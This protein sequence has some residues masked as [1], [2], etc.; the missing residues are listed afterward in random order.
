[1]IIKELVEN[2]FE[3]RTVM[4]SDMEVD[5]YVLRQSDVALPFVL[6]LIKLAIRDT[7]LESSVVSFDLVKQTQSLCFLSAENIHLKDERCA[8]NII[9]KLGGY[10]AVNQFSCVDDTI[11]IE[12]LVEEIR[13][14][15]QEVEEGKNIQV[16]S[17]LYKAVSGL[18]SISLDKSFVQ[19]EL[20]IM[21]DE[22][23]LNL[24]EGVVIPYNTCQYN[25]KA[26]T[27]I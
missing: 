24:T 22:N 21:N 12:K 5:M 15:L 6:L 2:F 11:Q 4:C 16:N 8:L 10:R 17:D 25:E 19:S 27:Q 18:F 7:E 14:C 1:M 13:H 20:E 3:Y 9:K 26:I 23:Y